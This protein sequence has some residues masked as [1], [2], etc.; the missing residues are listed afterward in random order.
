[1][2]INLTSPV[3]GG[4]Q[5]GLTSPTY[6]ITADNAPDSNSKQWAVTALGGTQTGV[7]TSTAADPFTITIRRPA[8]YRRIGTANPVT[9]V[10]SNVPRNKYEVLI[11]K[12]VVPLSGQASIPT[13]IRME[14]N[15]VSGSETAD[16]NNLRAGLSCA[17]G[18]LN[19][20][21]LELGNSVVTGSI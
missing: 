12:G 18:V 21:S 13:F 19:Q 10:V 8:S 1:M 15:A 3:T 16:A 9:G 17:I 4:A 20:I 5:T 7:N 11:R 14:I 6:T 2:A